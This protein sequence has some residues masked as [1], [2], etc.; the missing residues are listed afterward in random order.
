MKYWNSS[1]WAGLL[2][3]FLLMILCGCS[4][5]AVDEL[6]NSANVSTGV[7]G[8]LVIQQADGVAP[9]PPP[10]PTPKPSSVTGSFV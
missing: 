2:S 6:Q 4:L 9:P 3:S 5:L 1:K 10:L 7:S 8:T